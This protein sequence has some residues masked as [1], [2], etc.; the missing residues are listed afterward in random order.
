[1]A[2]SY[3][4]GYYKLSE[5]Q[6]FG[7]S[8]LYF[9]LGSIQFTDKEGNNLNI[10]NPKEYA[11]SAAYSRKLSEN[12][13]VALALKFIHSNLSG[14]ISLGPETETKPGNT[15]AGDLSVY[16]KKDFM[17]KG[18]NINFATG[19][20]ISNI[21]AKISY[22]NNEEKDFIPTNLRIG[23]STTADIDEYNKITFAFDANKLMVPSPPIYSDTN[24]NQMIV[25]GKDPNRPLLSGIFGSFSDAPGGFKEEMREIMLSF[26]LEYWYTDL[27]AVRAGYFNEHV[28]KGNRKYFTLG[29]G[30]RYQ[31][32]GLDFAY[33]TT[34]EQNHPLAETLRFTLLFDFE[35]FGKQKSIIE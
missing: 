35:A 20:N 24:G 1:M 28:T 16:Y 7:F 29:I 2:L 34:L 21:G 4:T 9:D 8:L 22:T 11:I 26:G 6:A 19:A 10:F 31:V 12:L 17:I 33:L 13:G 27:F 15:A 32:F 14:N 18:K 25:K 5:E 3:L 30:I 23:F